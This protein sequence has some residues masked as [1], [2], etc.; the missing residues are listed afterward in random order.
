LEKIDRVFSFSVSDDLDL[1]FSLSLS[2]S[3]DSDEYVYGS[4]GSIKK[5]PPK[6]SKKDAKKGKASD[7]V[8]GSEDR[9]TNGLRVMECQLFFMLNIFALFGLFVS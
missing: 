4:D 3:S 9:M 5:K 8:S 1:S 7:S 2:S 6:K